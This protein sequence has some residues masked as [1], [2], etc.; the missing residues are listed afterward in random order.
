MTD[1]ERLLNR[2]D[3][4]IDRIEPLLPPARPQSD[5]DAIA[6]RWRR[7]G[8]LQAV[9]HPQL[10][11]SDALLGVE[12]QKDL[13]AR[14]TEQFVR[15]LPANNALLWGSRGTGKSSLIRAMLDQFADRGLRLIE[16]ERRDL[17]DLPDIVEPLYAR[18]ERFIVFS[19]DLSFE[20]D[21]PSYKALK[22]TLDGS[23][24]AA[25]DNVLIYATSNRR[26]LLPEYQR[27][28]QDTRAV[29]GEIHHGEAVEEKI[30]LSERF[31]LW[32][33]FH[34]FGQDDY[35]D[36]VFHTLERMGIAFDA[37][38]VR[39]DA[40]RF[41]LER[42]SRSGRVAAQFARDWVGRNGL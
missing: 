7:P 41:A 31:G 11:E 14:N 9:K 2:L 16:V 24:A 35:L 32:L 12:R 8:Y 28:N 38:T 3:A 6:F 26:H 22:A 39:P 17:A 29:D 4:L 20:A 13:L 18:E 21:D 25:P 33:A 30:S 15:G 5:W 36:I 1:I 34:P 27:D 23:V 19:D 37:E 42:G 40:L 10:I